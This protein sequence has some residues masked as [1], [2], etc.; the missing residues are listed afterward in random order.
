[1]NKT[2]PAQLTFWDALETQVA[3]GLLERLNLKHYLG[4]FPTRAVWATFVF[5]DGFLTVAVLALVAML[6]GTPFVFPSVGPT[7]FMFFFHPTTPS[8]SPR[9]AILGHGVALLCGYLA[10]TLAGLQNSPSA[11]AEGVGWKRMLA[12]ALSLAL[13]GALMISFRIVH[14]PAAA[15]ALIVSLGIV[16]EPFQLLILELAIV[17]LAME[18]VAINRLAGVEYPWWGRK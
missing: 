17:L 9:N 7:T 8:S 3:Q 14:P 11:M 1:M 6:S 4:R 2:D 10:L 12:A 15:T 5:I 13:T 18:A 16:R